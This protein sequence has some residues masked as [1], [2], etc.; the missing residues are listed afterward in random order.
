MFSIV[1]RGDDVC[2]KNLYANLR[3]AIQSNLTIYCAGWVCRDMSSMN[4]WQRPLLPGHHK[5]V[6]AGKA[7]A[8][9]QTLDSSLQ[10]IR[11]FRPDI[12]LL[13]NL[14]KKKNI[15]IARQAL[16]A[17]GGYCTCVLLADSRSFAVP[18]S[19]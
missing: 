8:S 13:E 11:I 4:R 16:K 7:G 12:A 19:R 6:K 1:H 3:E 14:V 15:L 10:Y 2:S 18:M 17:M 5:D 9:S